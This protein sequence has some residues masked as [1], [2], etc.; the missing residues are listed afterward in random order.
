MPGEPDHQLGD[1]RVCAVCSTPLNYQEA[2]GWH[3][4]EQLTPWDHP[5]VPVDPTELA[6]IAWR[7]DFCN[8]P[9]RWLLPVETFRMPPT[10]DMSVSDWCV[11][12]RCKPAVEARDWLTIVGWVKERFQ[13]HGRRFD[14]I[15]V[16]YMLDLYK[17]LD[18]HITGPIVLNPPTA[19]KDT[20]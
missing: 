15:H 6:S 12:D 18:R 7:C 14:E 4:P 1:E 2:P 13:A 3:H 19:R 11:C 5:A 10:G 9:A 16:K 17:E 20:P 8:N